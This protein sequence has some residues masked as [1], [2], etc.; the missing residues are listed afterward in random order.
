MFGR[1]LFKRDA[2]IHLICSSDSLN[3]VF[4]FLIVLK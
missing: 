4:F 1:Q 2:P 3:F